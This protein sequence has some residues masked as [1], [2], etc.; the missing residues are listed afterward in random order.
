M[1]KMRTSYKATLAEAQRREGARE[2]YER[3][4]RHF[5]RSERSLLERWDKQLDQCELQRTVSEVA[6]AEPLGSEGLP[7]ALRELLAA[8]SPEASPAAAAVSRHRSRP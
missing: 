6:A 7:P 1:T 4:L 8:A 3:E 2:A 5:L